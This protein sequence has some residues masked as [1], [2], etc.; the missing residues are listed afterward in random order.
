YQQ[1]HFTPDYW[2]NY[3]VIG[4]EGRLENSGDGEGGEV[5]VWNRRTRFLERGHEQHP[6]VGDRDGHGDADALTV[7]EFV[8]FVRD[9]SP[10]DTSPLSARDAVAAGVA[11]TESIRHGS[12]PVT[13]PR[14]PKQL[15]G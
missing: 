9:G 5:R 7:A 6:I 1:C 2:R 3:T 10:A 11:G 14:I 4:T 12:R 13:V 15:R 8:A